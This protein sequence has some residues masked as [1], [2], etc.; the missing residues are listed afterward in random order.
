VL[1]HDLRRSVIR[2]GVPER[3]AMEISGHKMRAVFDRCNIVSE[4]ALSDAASR[5]AHFGR[6]EAFQG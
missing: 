2:S 4:P 5:T 3:V 6:T 1:L